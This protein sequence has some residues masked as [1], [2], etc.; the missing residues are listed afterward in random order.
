MYSLRKI[1]RGLNNPRLIG[2]ELNRIYH[3]RNGSQDHNTNGTDVF[4]EDWDNLIIL[5]ACRYE[6]FEQIDLEGEL[7]SRVSK[8]ASTPEFLRGNFRGKKLYDTVYVTANP[9]FSEM[10][11][12][13]D[14]DLFKVENVWGGE[15]WNNIFDTVM[16]E[17]VTDKAIE[18]FEENS[19]KR[20]VVHYMQPHYPFV[21]RDEEIEIPTG[22]EHIWHKAMSGEVDVDPEAAW[23]DYR[24]TFDYV[25]EE[26]ERLVENLEG[27][28]VVTADHGNVYGERVSPIP[29]KEW[30]HPIGIYDEKLVKVPWLVI[31][32]ERREIKESEKSSEKES[33][34]EEIKDKLSKL[35]YK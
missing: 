3:T 16:P 17:T 15:G 10:K 22:I 35:G 27:K 20:L 29:I 6:L 30:G 4:E 9:H 13:I 19:D 34:E 14:S 31:D 8:G 23:S 25:V 7:Q 28:T 1:K 24:K 33:E 11:E 5:D 18:S 2:R 21:S 32:G 26:V 12:D